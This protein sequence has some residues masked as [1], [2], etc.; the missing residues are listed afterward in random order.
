MAGGT[1]IDKA[2]K[3]LKI[4]DI[5]TEND[6]MK[7][8]YFKDE[9]MCTADPGQFV[10]VWVPHTVPESINYEIPDQVPMGVSGVYNNI[11]SI[12]VRNSGLTTNELFK[13]KTG[14]IL[15]VTGPLGK[16]FTIAGDNILCVAGGI[17]AAPLSFLVQKLEKPPDLVLG[18]T[19]KS[20]LLYQ[21]KLKSLCTLH[22]TTDDGS[23]GIKGFATDPVEEICTK[24]NIDQIYC[25]GPEIMMRKVFEI[26]VNHE[27][28][29]QFLLERYLY[30]GMGV[31]G[32]CTVD[33]Y[34]VCEDGPVFTAEQLKSV[35]DFGVKKVDE[36]GK[37]VKI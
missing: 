33:G 35:K 2:M 31:C 34:L 36:T 11:F 16:G 26:A 8:F 10:M 22:I 27:I 23:Y 19:T 30:C 28:P 9:S 6:T 24:N 13:Y 37:K 20:E 7:S 25:C 32:H 1:M 17:G 15:G 14:D 4:V 29:A 21:E 5:T 12:T 3:M 18:V